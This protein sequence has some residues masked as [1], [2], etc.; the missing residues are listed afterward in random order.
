MAFREL[1]DE[2]WAFIAPSL[3][4]Q[5]KTGRPQVDDRKVLNGIL[6]VLVTGCRRCDR[7]RQYGSSQTTW[8][9]HKELQEEGVW[10]KTLQAL[11]DW[12]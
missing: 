12:G 9:R 4:P 8:R 1:T 3:P 11:L 6:A 10:E 2:P 5:A 7:P